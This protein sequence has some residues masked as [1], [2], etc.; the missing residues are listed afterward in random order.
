MTVSSSTNKIIG[1]GNGITT[2]WPFSFKVFDPGHIVVTY[3]DANGTETTLDPGQ[4]VVNLNADQDASP[5]GTVVY[6]PAIASGTKLTILREV[7]YTQ[8]T[9]IKNQGGFFPEVLERGFDLVVMQV[10]QL[11]EQLARSLKLSSSQS[12]IGELE[13]TD[14]NRAN[15]FLGFGPTGLLTLFGGLASTAVSLA[16]QPVTA[17]ASLAAARTAMGVPGLGANTFTGA[18]TL[19]AN[20]ANALEAVPK[21]QAETIA[22][23]AALAAVP[24]GSLGWWPTDTPPAGWL[25]RDGSLISRTTY[26]ALFDVLV[27][28][29][30]FTGQ[31]FTVTIASPG[32]VT[33]AGHGFTGGERLRLSTTGALPTGVDT[34]NDFFVI[35]VDAN[36]FRL[37]TSEA[38]AAA[39]TAINTSGSQSGTH[40]YTRSLYGLGDGSTTFKLPDDRDLFM[41]GKPT[42]GRSIGTYQPDDNKAHA[43]DIPYQ[44]AVLAGGVG[45]GDIHSAGTT[46]PTGSSGNEARPKNRAYLPIIRY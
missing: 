30:G 17:A 20:A 26:A 29:P 44:A 1:N 23:A 28:Q 27:T 16:M 14:T 7:P 33:K 19:P 37:A 6:S 13:A 4:Y 43:H 9:D 10:Q 46:K 21:Q 5:G 12:A 38:N 34:T 32:V 18:Q 22:A 2:S 31:T 40:T 24:V 45:G 15:T 35:Y 11:R 3:V 42:S 8:A 39:G 41:R 25:A 36:T